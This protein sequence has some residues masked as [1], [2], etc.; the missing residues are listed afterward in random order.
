[1][2]SLTVALRAVATVILT[3]IGNNMIKLYRMMVV[4]LFSSCLATVSCAGSTPQKVGASGT[5]GK[6]E[7]GCGDSVQDI[8]EYDRFLDVFSEAVNV[9]DWLCVTALTGFP[10]EVRA[11]L[12]GE[13]ALALDRS[14]FLSF[15]KQFFKEETYLNIDDNL[16]QTTYREIILNREEEK[17]VFGNEVYLHGFVFKRESGGWK[18]EVGRDSNPH[19]YYTGV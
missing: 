8:Q 2:R 5:L 15:I 19:S 9:R 12:D 11:E 4:L 16:V 7:E 13:E 18:L 3:R 17:E 10:L 1:M 14:D 6:E